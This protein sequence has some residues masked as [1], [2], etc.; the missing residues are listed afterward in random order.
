MKASRS[1]STSAP[2]ATPE[3]VLEEPDDEL[4]GRSI[5]GRFLLVEIVGSTAL[6]TL[7]LVRRRLAQLDLTTVFGHPERCRAVQR[8]PRR[9]VRSGTRVRSSR[10]SRRA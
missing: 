4:R 6:T 5:A 1:S 3:R 2:E 8:N 7:E 9:S 10:W